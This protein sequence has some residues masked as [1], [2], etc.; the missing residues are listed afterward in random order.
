[1]FGPFVLKL[2]VTSANAKKTKVY[3]PKGEKWYDTREDKLYSGGQTINKSVPMDGK[4]HYM[5]RSGAIIPTWENVRQLKNALWDSLTIYLLP[6]Y[7]DDTS[8]F[9]LYEDDG[10]TELELN[11]F[12]RF[13]FYMSSSI[14]KIKRKKYGLKS[15]E[16]RKATL[17]LLDG[18]VFTE[19]NMST[20][21]YDPDNTKYITLGIK[22]SYFL[23]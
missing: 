14:L 3:L 10:V 2:P 9:S 7:K 8:E 5:L 17:Q 15:K 12:N 6:P 11:K 20:F 16:A 13:D 22:D 23:L 21:E 18:Y 4:A 1:M 19:N